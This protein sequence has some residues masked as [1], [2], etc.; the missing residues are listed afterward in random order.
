MQITVNAV[1]RLETHRRAM[2]RLTRK[3]RYT[4]LVVG[5]VGLVGMLYAPALK[6]LQVNDE[7][8]RDFAYVSDIAWVFALIGLYGWVSLEGRI[9]RIAKRDAGDPA[10]HGYQMILTEERLQYSDPDEDFS[11]KWT[12]IGRV[13]EYHDMWIVYRANGRNAWFIPKEGLVPADLDVFRAFL[14]SRA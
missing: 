7:A 10:A 2:R 9:N 14:A 5:L 8:W 6:L 1:P 3:N 13:R 11:L 12:L 4:Y